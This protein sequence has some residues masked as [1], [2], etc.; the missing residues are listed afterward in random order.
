VLKS[1]VPAESLT[2]ELLALL[3]QFDTEYTRN[4]EPKVQLISELGGHKTDDVRVALE[5]FLQDAS[6]PVRFATVTSLFSISAVESLPALL[7]A[8]AAEESLRVKNR[9]AQGIAEREWELPEELAELGQRALPDG[10]RLEGRRF[11]KR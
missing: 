11:K 10:Y 7:S 2:E 6:E 5:P 1:I 9:I 4:V 8:L 3:D